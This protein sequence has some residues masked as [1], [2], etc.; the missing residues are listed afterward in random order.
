MAKQGCFFSPVQIRRIINLLITTDM[1]MAEIAE[2]IQC[3]RSAIVSINRKFR[4]REYLGRR[5]GW[6]LQKEEP[7]EVSVSADLAVHTH[8]AETSETTPL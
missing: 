6:S 1:T 3:S 7:I 4:V 5:S 2:R 8:S